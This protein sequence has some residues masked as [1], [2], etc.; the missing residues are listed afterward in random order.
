VFGSTNANIAS[1]P[2]TVQQNQLLDTSTAAHPSSFSG[3]R[4]LLPPAALRSSHS[5]SSTP[6]APSVQPLPVTCVDIG[7]M[8]CCVVVQICHRHAARRR[9]PR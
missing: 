5:A 2:H 4:S 6:R 8:Q 7:Q 1:G 9:H 3:G